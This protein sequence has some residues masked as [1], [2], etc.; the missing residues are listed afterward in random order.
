MVQW[1]GRVKE[2]LIM[3]DSV[4]DGIWEPPDLYEDCKLCGGC[5]LLQWMSEAPPDPCP[6]CD[7][8]RE[9]KR[10]E[11]EKAAVHSRCAQ[12]KERS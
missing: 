7:L 3:D 5:G 10:R 1:R 12:Q 11:D 6:E 9:Y 4:R 8:G 2:V